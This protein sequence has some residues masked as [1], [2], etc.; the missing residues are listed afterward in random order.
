MNELGIIGKQKKA[1]KAT[2]NSNHLNPIADRVFKTTETEVTSSNTYFAGD[3]TYIKL[4]DK[5]VYL[6]VVMD[7]Y[8]REIVGWSLQDHLKSSLIE[9]ALKKSSF[10]S[11][12]PQAVFHSD[13]GVQYASS[14]YQECLKQ[15]SMIQSM[16]RK[17]NCYDNAYV[18]SF[19]ATLKKELIYKKSYQTIEELRFELF[20]Y[21]EVFYNR[22]RS[23]SSLDYMS[24]V[25]YKNVNKRA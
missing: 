7:L 18:E 4:K 8:N 17:G 3:I 19:F 11:S 25:E 15:N 14:S 24:P 12:L 2:T 6:S 9:A 13:R 22:K 20:D 23:H 1:Y 16:S 10:N 5:F 21:I